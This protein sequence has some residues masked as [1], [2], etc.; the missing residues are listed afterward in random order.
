[1]ERTGLR[2]RPVFAVLLVVGCARGV[3]VTVRNDSRETISDVRVQ[4]QKDL[5]QREATL[6]TIESG[7][8]A[9]TE[10]V[11]YDAE[12]PIRLRFRER[13]GRN[14]DEAIDVYLERSHRPITL[15]VTME[16][17]VKCEGC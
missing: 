11:Y 1:M 6:G 14:H 9:Q 7:K 5:Q 8:S 2:L 4:Y 17:A 3:E 15:T 13:Q 12:R 10:I 16:Y